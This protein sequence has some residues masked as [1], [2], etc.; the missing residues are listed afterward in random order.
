MKDTSDVLVIGGGV[1]GLTAARQLANAGLR[2]TL[3][4]ARDR[5]GGRVWT[6]Q[7]AEYPVELGAEFV[8]GR[9]EEILG[10]AAE[11][12]LPIVPVAGDFRRKI[13]GGWANAWPLMGQ[14]EKL[15]EKMPADEPDQSFQHYVDRAGPAEEVREQALRYVE[16]FHA[17]DPSLISVHSLIRDIRAEEAIAGDDQQFRFAGGYEGVVNAIKHRIEPRRCDLMLNTVVTEIQWRH[18][19]VVAKTVSAEFR[20]PRAIITVPLSVLK[21]NSMA[22]SP[23]LPAKL[24]AMSFFEMGPAVRVTLCFREKFWQHGLEMAD[25]GF[26]F[27]D[28]PQFPTW[29]TS[30]ALPYPFLTGWAA[31]KYALAMK[32]LDAGEVTHN[33]TT[34]LARILEIRER[35]LADQLTGAFT[36]DWQSDPFSRGAYSYAAVGGIDA[37]QALA[38]PVAETLYF[39]GEATNSEGYN[40]T[41]HGAMATGYRAAW[42]LLIAAGIKPQRTA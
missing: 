31:G 24:H 1:A 41:V 42:E 39:A 21:S 14:V 32:G 8:H 37:A 22:F 29:W 26:L 27:T 36:H 16:G 28:D 38:A 7:T 33:A 2:V 3:L 35:D 34:A 40:G 15:F 13:K 25:M 12:G 9:P 20:A 30:N 10:L 11:A 19:E 17:A 4:E 23:A 6:D 5:L 18:G